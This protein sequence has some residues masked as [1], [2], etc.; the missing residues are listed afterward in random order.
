M[1]ESYLS[2]QLH[3]MQSDLQRLY[4]TKEDLE[5]TAGVS[6]RDLKAYEKL[7]YPRLLLLGLIG[8]HVQQILLLG[9]GLIPLS[10]LVKWKWLRKRQ[11]NLFDEVEKY[12]V[13]IKAIEINDQLVAAG[14]KGVSL[15]DREKIITTLETTRANLICALKTERILR[16]NRA[17]INRNSELLA[18]HLAAMQALQISDEAREYSRLLDEALRI[19]QDVQTEMKTLEGEQRN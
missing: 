11:K 16:E 2:H 10:Y 7:K 1:K 6:Q 8:E 4:I 9:W 3:T 14:N 12:N 17:F 5:S 19:A 18:N 13:V 15:I